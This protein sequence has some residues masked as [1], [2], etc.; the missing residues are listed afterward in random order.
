MR[1]FKY[2]DTKKNMNNALKEQYASLTKDEKRLFRKHKLWKRIFSIVAITIF[3]SIMFTGIYFLTLIPQPKTWYWGV[4]YGIGMMLLGFILLL[5]SGLAT[6][7]VTLPLQKKSDKYYVRAM[8]K[9]I[10]SKACA[11]LRDYYDLEEP[12]IVTKCYDSTIDEFKNHD[13]CIFVVGNELRITADIVR[14]FLH[15]ERDLGCYSFK[16]DEISLTKKQGNGFL[17][18]EL[19]VGDAAFSLGYRAKSFIKNNFLEKTAD[20]KSN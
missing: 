3:F 20:D 14:G 19:K 1:Y 17:I 10:C 13:V 9:E 11:H 8:K 15:G 12:Y 6:L 16:A 5:V 2:K 7:F 4:L 18:A